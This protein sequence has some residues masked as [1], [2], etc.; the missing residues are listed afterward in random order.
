[1][2]RQLGAANAREH[3]LKQRIKDLEAE[4]AKLTELGARYKALAEDLQAATGKA[5]KP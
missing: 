5:G 4:N 3:R 1:M 2:R